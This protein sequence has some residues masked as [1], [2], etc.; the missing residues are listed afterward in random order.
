MVARKPSDIGR[1]FEKAVTDYVNDWVGLKVC[2]RIR[3]HGDLD[4]GDLRLMVDNVPVA[5]E[6]KRYKKYPGESLMGSFRDETLKE[7]AH[8]GYDCSVLVVNRFRMGTR[9]AEVWMTHGTFARLMGWEVPKGHS[10][11][12]WVCK[13]LLEFCWMC[14]GAPA[15]GL[16][17]LCTKE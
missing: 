16:E 6:C 13:T 1:E 5:V 7:M 17:E 11:H 9:R 15:W 3:Q 12:D 8:A 2:E 4:E 10:E 14:F